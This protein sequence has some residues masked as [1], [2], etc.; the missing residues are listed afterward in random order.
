MTAL[1]ATNELAV[2]PGAWYVTIP[3]LDGSVLTAP[4]GFAI[5]S[6]SSTGVA[7]LLGQLYDGTTISQSVPV[8]GNGSL[9]LYFS[10]YRGQGLIAGWISLTGGL[11]TGTVTWIR[12]TDAISPILESGGFTNVVNIY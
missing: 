12:P 11:P 8:A 5:L 6:M 10:L 4:Q 9:P 2:P 7:T 1:L 3:P